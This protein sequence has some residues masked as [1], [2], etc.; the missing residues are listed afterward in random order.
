MLGGIG[1]FHGSSIVDR[2]FAQAWD[3]D[4]EDS[5][6]EPRERTPAP[7][8][9]EP[10]ELF[11]A[12]PSRPFFPRGFYWDEGFHLLVVGAWDND[13][14]LAILHDWIGLI[15][16][17]GWVAREQILGEE[18][19]SKVPKEFWTQYPHH[20]NPPTLAMAVTAFVRRLRASSD[21]NEFDMGG[22]D[23]HQRILAAS[24]ATTSADERLASRHLSSPTLGRAYLR[25]IYASLKR[26]YAWFRRTQRGQSDGR[27]TGY[28]WRGRTA[29]HVLT[30]GLDDYPRAAVPSSGELHLDLACWMAFFGKTM[31]EIAE[32]VGEDEDREEYEGHARSLWATIEGARA[33]PGLE[34][35]R[36][37]SAHRAALERG[38]ADVLRRQPR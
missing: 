22:A 1:Y 17:D 27:P 24:A 12:T 4:D 15:D 26:H 30:S 28:R 29:T 20:A 34:W 3:E 13:L 5:A 2:S 32:A 7:L 31:A 35:R 33:G 6:L 18:A 36:S 16:D 10:R 9:S 14:S 38:G 19:R 21:S 11:T 25:S 37:H 8:L 23:P